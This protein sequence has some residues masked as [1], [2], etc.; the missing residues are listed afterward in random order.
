MILDVDLP[1]KNQQF[2]H[3]EL[4]YRGWKVYNLRFALRFNLYLSSNFP[5]RFACHRQ[6][7][8]R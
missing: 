6:V 4:G 2:I 8:K 5:L 3:L 1:L 7:L